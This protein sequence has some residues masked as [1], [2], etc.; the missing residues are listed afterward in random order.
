M[1]A[2]MAPWHW[3]IIHRAPQWFQHCNTGLQRQFRHGRLLADRAWLP[4]AGLK[5]RRLRKKEPKARRAAAKYRVVF[6]REGGFL[7][8]YFDLPMS[9]KKTDALWAAETLANVPSDDYDRYSLWHRG[10]LQSTTTQS[11]G[12]SP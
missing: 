11:N 8:L 1:V 2:R 10:T 7:V 5:A 6:Q 4:E 9:R 3:R 12:I